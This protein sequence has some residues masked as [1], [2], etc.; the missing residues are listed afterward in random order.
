MTRCLSWPI[1]RILPADLAGWPQIVRLIAATVAALLVAALIVGGLR[2]E[3]AGGV[4]RAAFVAAIAFLIEM[5]AGGV[6]MT[7]GAS[8]L[9][10]VIYV[11]AAVLLWCMLVLITVRAC[12]DAARPLRGL[13]CLPSRLFLYAG[14]HGFSSYDRNIAPP[15]VKS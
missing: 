1:W 14:G 11:A 9:L 13:Q 15:A 6:M 12:L 2:E 4:R 7:S 10:A 3:G 5:L 8:P